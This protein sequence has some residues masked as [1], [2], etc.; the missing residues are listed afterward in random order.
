MCRSALIS[1]AFT[2]LVDLIAARQLGNMSPYSSNRT[3][4]HPFIVVNTSSLKESRVLD[5]RRVPYAV[6]S[7]TPR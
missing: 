2:A 1:S 5:T 6:L 7:T 4:W 3:L